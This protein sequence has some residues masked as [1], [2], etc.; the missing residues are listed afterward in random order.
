MPSDLETKRLVLRKIQRED[1]TPIFECWMQDEDV[2]RY[3][4]W[5]ASKDRSDTEEFVQFELGNLDNNKWNRWIIVAKDTKEIIGTCLIFWNEE[6]CHFDISY[7]LGKKYW[8]K[9]YTT[10]AMAQVMRYG[11]EVLGI[12]EYITSCA[13]ENKASAHV[14]EKL[15]FQYEKDV[16]YAC[17][18]GEIK[19]AGKLYRWRYPSAG[20]L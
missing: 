18:G 7:N 10:E 17:N 20:R 11:T 15:G 5:K 9:G 6:D 19:T 13:R 12:K 16:P 3:M 14:L 4:W 1:V 8:G 2:S